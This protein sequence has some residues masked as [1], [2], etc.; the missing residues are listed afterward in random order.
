MKRIE[1]RDTTE[2]EEQLNVEGGYR[3]ESDLLYGA[4]MYEKA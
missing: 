3:A 4:P 1:V 2:S